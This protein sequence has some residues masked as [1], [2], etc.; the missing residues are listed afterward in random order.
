MNDP[1]RDLERLNDNLAA[2]ALDALEAEEAAQLRIHLEGCDTC[3]DRLMWLM[4]AVDQLPAAVEQ[5]TPPESLRESLMATVRAETAPQ[6]AQSRGPV[7]QRRTWWDGLRSAT[8]RPATGM[9][10]LIVLVVGVGSG[11]LLRGSDTA[12]P[13]GSSLVKAEAMNGSVPV[14]ATLERTGDSATLHVHELP[15]LNKDDVYEV[16]VQRAGVMEP[17]STFVLNSD[18]TAEAAVPGPLDGAD[19]VFVTREPRG[20]SRQPTTDPLLQAPL[21]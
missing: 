17:R 1:H 9:A 10:V 11:Y 15:V 8:L 2:Y 13:Q 16:W 7:P 20:G 21:Q 18:G 12:E 6:A 5:R 14:S 19:G 4:P 3:R